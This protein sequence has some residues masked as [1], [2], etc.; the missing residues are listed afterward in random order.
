MHE[1]GD[2]I[3]TTLL[4]RPLFSLF[5]FL[6]TRLLG[7]VLYRKYCCSVQF[8]FVMLIKV[9]VRCVCLG[10]QLG[11]KELIQAAIKNYKLLVK[12]HGKSFSLSAQFF[13]LSFSLVFVNESSFLNSI[14]HFSAVLQM[15]RLGFIVKAFPMFCLC[16]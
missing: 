11:D 13:P 14:S 16:S 4:L 15:C 2:C 7:E 1:K 10:F 3:K 8:L 9:C 6:G 5:Y 12:N